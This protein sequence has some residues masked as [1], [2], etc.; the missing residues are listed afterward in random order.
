ME[1]QMV[2]PTDSPQQLAGPWPR[3]LK[4]ISIMTLLFCLVQLAGMGGYVDRLLRLPQWPNSNYDTST[5][6]SGESIT[7]AIVTFTG[8]VDVFM[9]G[10]AI[11]LY[12]RREAAV[13]I[14]GLWLWLLAWAA[15]VLQYF[16]EYGPLISVMTSNHLLHNAAFVS[17][18][19]L[20]LLVLR[21]YTGHWPVLRN[22]LK[23][24]KRW[25]I[26]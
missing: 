7:M 13:L 15:G 18:P 22:P 21:E 25:L 3:L 10:G 8:L 6:T 24:F 14:I 5:R 16:F 26:D 9:A 23:L 2:I 20:V 1:P 4:S 19:A 17:V 12:R 11:R